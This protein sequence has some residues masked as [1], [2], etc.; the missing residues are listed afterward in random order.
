M[1]GPSSPSPHTSHSPF[2]LLGFPLARERKTERKKEEG[3]ENSL[4]TG[5][6]K[7]KEKYEATTAKKQGHF[8]NERGKER[9]RVRAKKGAKE[10]KGCM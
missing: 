3:Q 5:E 4:R 10:L 6:P 8:L 7:G 9:V 2:S 1:A